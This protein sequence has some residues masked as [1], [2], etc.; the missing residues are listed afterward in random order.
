MQYG[1]EKLRPKPHEEICY[2]LAKPSE[3]NKRMLAVP[4]DCFKTT[5]LNGYI[6]YDICKHLEEGDLDFCYLLDS[7]TITLAEKSMRFIKKRLTQQEE[8][9]NRYGLFK[10]NS[11]WDKR[12]IVIRQQEE[13]IKAGRAEQTIMASSAESGISGFHFTFIVADDWVTEKQIRTAYAIERT[14]SHYREILSV[15]DKDVGQLRMLC[16]FWHYNDVY[17]DIMRNESEDWEIMVRPIYEEKDGKIKLFFPERYPLSKIQNLKKTLGATFYLQYML[18]PIPEEEKEFPSQ[19]YQEVE[20]ELLPQSYRYVYVSYDPADEN[21]SEKTF[22]YDCIGVI[23]ID[24]SYNQYLLELTI[25]RKMSVDDVISTIIQYVKKYKKYLQAVCVEKVLFFKY[26]RDTFSNA[27]TYYNEYFPLLPVQI[28]RFISK[29][30]RIKILTIPWRNQQIYIRAGLN[31]ELKQ[32]VKEEFNTFPKCKFYDV[33]DMWAMVCKQIIVD[34]PEEV[35]EEKKPQRELIQLCGT[36]MVF[37]PYVLMGMDEEE[38][39]Q[40]EL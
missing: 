28:D 19:Y 23:G 6:I 2:F 40:N 21:L 36:N 9:I 38:G 32:E 7:A 3:K 17:M 39:E 10:G 12:N 26:L 1:Y 24:H 16:T 30:D 37:N 14:K 22:S 8:L 34:S 20:D 5:I 31:E 33:L 15:L 29:K 35:E 11:V 18:M 27:M 4:R 25:K 13:L